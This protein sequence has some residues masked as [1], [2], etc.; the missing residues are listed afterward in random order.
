MHD[1]KQANMSPGETKRKSPDLP[2]TASRW[3]TVKAHEERGE[4]Y[5]TPTTQRH[6]AEGRQITLSQYARDI[7]TTPKTPTGGAEGREPKALRGA[8]G[9]DLMAQAQGWR[10]PKA[11]ETMGRYSQV[12]GKKYPSLWGQA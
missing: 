6:Y 11:G 1:I 12:D 5:R 7:W 3:P 4:H 8:G 10:T 9:A 2:S